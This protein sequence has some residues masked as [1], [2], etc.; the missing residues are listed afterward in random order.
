MSKRS[1]DESPSPYR[2]NTSHTVGTVRAEK[3]RVLA[4]CGWTQGADCAYHGLPLK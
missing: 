3:P 1:R 2:E 4:G